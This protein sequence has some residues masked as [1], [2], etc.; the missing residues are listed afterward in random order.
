MSQYK[1]LVKLDHNADHTT[2]VYVHGL[3]KSDEVA[4]AW[5]SAHEDARCIDVSPDAAISDT[6]L[7]Y[8]EKI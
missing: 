1:L 8:A 5:E 3:T 4:Q 7:S 6:E 2:A